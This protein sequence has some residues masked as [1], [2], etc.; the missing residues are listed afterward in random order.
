MG[1]EM[2]I[3]DSQLAR[4]PATKRENSLTL[5]IGF[6]RDKKTNKILDQ[7]PFIFFPGN[8][9]RVADCRQQLRQEAS[10]YELLGTQLEDVTIEIR[11]DADVP[12]GLIQDL[13]QICQETGYEDQRFQRFALK[14][15]QEE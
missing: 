8:E 3:R 9:V 5:N 15:T 6:H 14:A 13:I 12:T 4:P 10:T 1:S 11:A 2:C 7:E